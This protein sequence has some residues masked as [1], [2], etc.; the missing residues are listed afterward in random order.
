MV[1]IRI[2]Q[3]FKLEVEPED[4]REI[5]DAIEDRDEQYILEL[6]EG[7]VIGYEMEY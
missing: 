1:K 4:L 7:K 5:T 6:V 2:K 3:V